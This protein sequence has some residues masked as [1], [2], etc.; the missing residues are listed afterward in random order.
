M[1][2]QRFASG[3]RLFGVLLVAER[4]HIVGRWRGC[5]AN[6]VL[7]NPLASKHGRC[8]MGVGG[9]H[10]DGALAEQTLARLVCER[11]TPVLTAVDLTESVVLR[12]PLVDEGVVGRHQVEDIAI[13]VHHALEE[14]LGLAQHRLSQVVVKIRKLE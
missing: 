12:Q 4:R 6:D 3:T 11:H 7:Q 5:N 14:E 9:H 2:L 1:L 8:A 13:L 10:E